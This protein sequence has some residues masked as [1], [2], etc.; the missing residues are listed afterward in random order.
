MRR[1]REIAAALLAA[2]DDP[3]LGVRGLEAEI[4]AGGER[5][6]EGDAVRDELAERRARRQAR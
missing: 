2:L 5:V 1:A 3:A 4:E 6:A